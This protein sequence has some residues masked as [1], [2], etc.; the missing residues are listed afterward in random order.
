MSSLCYSSCSCSLIFLEHLYM[1]IRNKT[2]TIL[3]LLACYC[4]IICILLYSL[5]TSAPLL[6]LGSRVFHTPYPG[7]TFNSPGECDDSDLV[8]CTVDC[9][10]R[11]TSVFMFFDSALQSISSCRCTII[12]IIAYGPLSCYAIGL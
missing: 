4:F 3:I 9:S 8:L 2:E 7:S 6:L 1:V 5:S 11:A 12:F 10:L